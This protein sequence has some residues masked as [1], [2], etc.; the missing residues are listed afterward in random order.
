M[1]SSLN[2]ERT[3][4]TPNDLT[5]LYS[6]TRTHTR[7]IYNIPTFNGRIDGSGSTFS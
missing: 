5:V 6:G 1:L 3:H 2:F 4:S 7:G